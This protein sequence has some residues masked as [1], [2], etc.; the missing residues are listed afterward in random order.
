[1]KCLN[2]SR[3]WNFR[4]QIWKWPAK[5]LNLTAQCSGSCS[6]L[7]KVLVW[8]TCRGRVWRRGR[9]RR[10]APSRRTAA[11]AAPRAAWWRW[12]RRTPSAARGR[13]TRSGSRTTSTCSTTCRCGGARRTPRGWGWWARAAARRRRVQ[14]PEWPLR[15]SHAA[16]AT[17]QANFSNQRLEKL[18]C[19]IRRV[20]YYLHW[21]NDVE[22]LIFENHKFY[23]KISLIARFRYAQ[24]STVIAEKIKLF[25]KK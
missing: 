2:S 7:W 11:P 22:L 12:P 8:L 17:K 9:R 6:R 10:R 3:V 14:R 13:G 5:H 25:K 18:E 4:S 1:M 19:L 23:L 16:P 20:D 24:N 21:V 15:S